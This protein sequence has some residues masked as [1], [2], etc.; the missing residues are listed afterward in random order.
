MTVWAPSDCGCHQLHVRQRVV[1]T[2]GPG[3]GKTAVLELARRHL[4]RHVDV[5]PE[6][7][8]VLFSGGLRRGTTTGARA[9]AQRAIFHVQ[10]SLEAISDA[11]EH[12]ALVVCDRGT[13]DGSAYWPSPGDFFAAMGTDREQELARYHTVIHLRTPPRSAYNHRN[14]L[15]TE[16]SDEAAAIDERIAAVWEGH[17]RRF[18]IESTVSFLEKAHHAIALLEQEVPA[19]CRRSLRV[20][21][22]P[23]GDEA[24]PLPARR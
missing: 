14:P 17:P 8:S 5:L 6:A 19:C 10:R 18:V 2:G 3:A 12:A 1:L 16:S 9:A 13:V 7:A 4:C 23:A 15:R 22:R 21:R 24:A 20:E 11:E